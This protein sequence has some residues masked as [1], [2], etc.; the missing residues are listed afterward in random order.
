MGSQCELSHLFPVYGRFESDNSMPS[1]SSSILTIL[2]FYSAFIFFLL[3]MK[4]KHLS[5]DIHDC[6]TMVL[7]PS[8]NIIRRRV[9]FKKASEQRRVGFKLHLCLNS[10]SSLLRNNF[11][12][13][14]SHEMSV[15]R[16]EVPKKQSI[17]VLTDDISG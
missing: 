3:K 4:K 10:L 7:Y 17:S 5:I 6:L 1:L 14:K 12:V 8:E 13:I 11:L 15:Y 9:I 16:N 2:D